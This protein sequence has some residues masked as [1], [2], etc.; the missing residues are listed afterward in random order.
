[1]SDEA[2]LIGEAARGILAR[3]IDPEAPWQPIDEGGWIGIGVD[4][5]QGGHGGTLVEAA[6]VAEAAG[7]TAAAAP[8]VESMLAA[9]VLGACSA[10]RSLLAEL[11]EGRERVALVPRV[12]RSDHSGYVADH[13]LVV[14]W[15]RHATVVV[16]ITALAEGGLGLVVVPIGEVKLSHGETL[17]GDPLDRLALPSAQ[18]PA[19]VHDLDMP[20]EH[21]ISAAA[22]VTAARLCGAMRRTADLSVEY[23]NERSQ[24]G[25]SIGSFQAVAHALVRQA[26]HVAVAESALRLATSGGAGE[27]SAVAQAARVAAADAVDPV[28]KVAHQVHGAI[29]VTREHDLHRYT[30]RLI[31]WRT[32]FGSTQWWARRLG[33]RTL[34]SPRW[35]DETAPVAA[36]A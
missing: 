2:K 27:G 12:V 33:T 25:R 4:E 29:G 35:W 22:V 14:P 19:P 17:A 6:A 23:A 15:A 30:L 28:V 34:A 1:M 31:D 7:A 3:P 32:A 11:V 24:F 21:L 9:M 36:A 8:V 20:L 26:G 10:T 5:D 18:L 16:L 13:E